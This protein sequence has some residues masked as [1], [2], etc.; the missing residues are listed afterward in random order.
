M[1]EKQ[2][3]KED[4]G[5]EETVVPEQVEVVAET[6]ETLSEEDQAYFDG[7]GADE[8]EVSGGRKA[9]EDAEGEGK[10]EK[11]SSESEGESGADKVGNKEDEKNIDPVPYNR[12]SQKVAE[13]ADAKDQIANE[14]NLFDKILSMVNK[15]NETPKEEKS[16]EEEVVIPPY[17]DGEA[18]HLKAR[19]DLTDKK[20]AEAEQERADTKEQQDMQDRVA[21]F[22][23]AV[24]IEVNKFIETQ[25][26]YPDAFNHLVESRMKELATIGLSPDQINN[27]IIEENRNISISAAQQGKN[28][29]AVAYDLAIGRGYVK[30]SDDGENG[31]GGSEKVDKATA[32]AKAKIE[33]IQKGIDKNVSLG[34]S[35]G[36]GESK[37]G[38]DYAL[39]MSDDEFNKLSAKEVETLL[40]G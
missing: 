15:P 19:Q 31:A 14:R 12:F 9:D 26:D 2:E 24:G 35:G 13:L 23:E 3:T 27:Q 33:N 5:I 30:A 38:L 17:E 21:K 8:S 10:E 11:G 16:E 32:E 4:A 37:K 20:L 29:G 6:D 18:E 1:A 36:D 40:G 25:P 28:P 7:G 39:S 34:G 22:D